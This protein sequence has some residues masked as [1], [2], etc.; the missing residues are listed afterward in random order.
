M[1]PLFD[2]EVYFVIHLR[3]FFIL[4]VGAMYQMQLIAT[5]GLC[6]CWSRS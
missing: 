6:A 2:V 4:F 1:T 5:V 3:V